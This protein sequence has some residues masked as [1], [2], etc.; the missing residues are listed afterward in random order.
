MVIEWQRLWLEVWVCMY[1]QTPLFMG[2][3]GFG[4]LVVDVRTIKVLGHL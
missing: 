2:W 3:L 1:G 4:W